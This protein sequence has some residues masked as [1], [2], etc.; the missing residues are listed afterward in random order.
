[1]S[2]PLYAIPGMGVDE[3]LYAD[4]QIRN[5]ELRVLRWIEPRKKE[6]LPSYALRLAEQIDTSKPFALMGVSFG[7]MCAV[8]IAKVHAPQTLIL[9]ST[10]KA[11]HELPPWVRVARYL[12]QLHRLFSERFIATLALRNRWIFGILPGE[13]TRVFGDMLQKN[14][15]R[16][17]RETISAVM[18][19][20]N[21][22]VPENCVHFHGDADRLLPF[23]FVRSAQ[24]IPQ[25]THV[26]VM[27]DAPTLSRLIAEA[28]EAL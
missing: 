7:G 9:I 27:N 2:T 12:P 20:D 4:L 3:R 8:E 28:L 14:P 13:Q 6:S 16:Y 25:G 24:R 10:C 21:E 5:H 22:T 17:F 23:R 18:R 26:M 15:P 11:R 1:M 19:W